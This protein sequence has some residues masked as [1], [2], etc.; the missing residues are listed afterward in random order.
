MALGACPEPLALSSLECGW[1][2]QRAFSS[3]RAL[4]YPVLPLPSGPQDKFL[5]GQMGPWMTWAHSCDVDAGTLLY[6]EELGPL[7][8]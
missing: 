3:E 6:L 1:T 5:G 2:H 4:H 7:C 8:P